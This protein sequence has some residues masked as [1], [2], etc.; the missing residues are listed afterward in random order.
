MPRLRFLAL[1]L[2]AALSVACSRRD[3]SAKVVSSDETTPIK[4]ALNWVPEPEF[5]G[6]YAAREQG[7]YERAGLDVEIL[8]GGAGVPVMQM[9]A[10]GKV[11][12]GITGADDVVLAR[13]RGLDITAVFA[14]FQTHPQGIMAHASHGFESLEDVF[15]ADLT[16]ALEPGIPYAAWLLHRYGKGSVKIVPYDGGVARF[17]TDS[18]FAQQCY[19]TSEPISAR[20]E[21]VEPSV[22]LVSESGYEPYG[23]V[24]IARR[25]LIDEKPALVDSFVKASAE[26]WRAYLDDPAPTNQ[27]LQRLNS[28]MDQPSLLAAAEAQRPLIETEETQAR[29]L[30]T[31]N[32]QRWEK[33]ADQLV[34]ISLIEKA[35][36]VGELYR[37]FGENIPAKSPSP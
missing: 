14:T 34:E 3:T 22:F 26:G 21:G 24:V 15:R 1:A 11:D 2:V 27:L 7:A 17:L 18:K 9:V 30:G 19:V 12:F 25:S 13:A 32:P 5:G 16:L 36:P 8:G 20:Q 4:L 10:T 6:F 35:P 31:M 29:G 28:A 23:V 37:A 33:L